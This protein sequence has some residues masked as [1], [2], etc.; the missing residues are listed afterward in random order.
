VEGDAFVAKISADGS[1]LLY[2]TLLGGP[3]SENF[4]GGG[5]NPGI[6][7]DAAGH[8]YVTGETDSGAGFPT[9]PGAFHRTGG[10]LFI[11]KIHPSGGSLVYSTLIPGYALGDAI[12]VDA[13][14]QAYVTGGG[15]GLPTKNPF[16]PTL[17]PSGAFVLKLNASGSDVVF[18]SYLGGSVGFGNGFDVDYATAIAVDAAGDIYVGGRA[19][20]RDFPRVNAAQPVHGGAS[21]DGFVTK[22]HRSGAFIIYSTFIGGNDRDTVMGLAVDASGSVHA[23]GFTASGNFPAVNPLQAFGGGNDAFVT[24]LTPAGSAIAFSTTIGG[25]SSDLGQGVALDS[26]G[27]VY[28][29]GQTYSPDFPV[30]RPLPP[31]FGSGLEGD[32]FI[33]KLSAGGASILYSTYFGGD[34]LEYASAIAVDAAGSAYITGSAFYANVGTLPI[35]GGFQPNPG[36]GGPPFFGNIDAFVAK[37]ADDSGACPAEITDRVE[38]FKLGQQGLWFSPIR[39]EWILIRNISSGPL[40]GP[41]VLA[42][43]DLRN[44][45]LLGSTRTTSCL[46]SA[47]TPLLL[48]PIDRDGA[49]APDESALAGVWLYRTWFGTISYHARLLASMPVQ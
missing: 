23:A 22:I 1:T 6:A 41:L 47:R 45:V 42:I 14:G 19:A 26:R 49:L 27:N 9:T 10:T 15:G 2:A 35:V 30:V 32:A 17:S 5:G 12:A 25:S 8:A 33:T 40:R 28:L 7:V 4:F 24:R 18:S 21:I 13:L 36:A 3:R 48:V 39:F 16:M 31:S 43:D 44:A 46:G 20:S 11:T 34:N 37:V 29:A 38:V